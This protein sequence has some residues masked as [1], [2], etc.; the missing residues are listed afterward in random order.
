MYNGISTPK[1]FGNI[2]YIALH[3]KGIFYRVLI[4]LIVFGLAALNPEPSK[5]TNFP[6]KKSRFLHLLPRCGLE[7]LKHSHGGAAT[8]HN[9]YLYA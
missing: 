8:L 2:A 7:Y 1:Y 6:P 3:Y 4:S 5:I 9:P